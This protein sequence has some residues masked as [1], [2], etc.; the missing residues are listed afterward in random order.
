MVHLLLQE[1]AKSI[2]DEFYAFIIQWKLD[3][4]EKDPLTLAK[5]MNRFK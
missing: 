4:F 5:S 2:F 3:I 1:M